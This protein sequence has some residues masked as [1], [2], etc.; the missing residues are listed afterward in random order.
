MLPERIGS[1]CAEQGGEGAEDDVRQGT[2][3]Q[4]IREE[5]ADGDTWNRSWCK[6]RE[7][8]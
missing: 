6:K 7:D 1:E 8:G 3:G 5:A 2:S 4:D